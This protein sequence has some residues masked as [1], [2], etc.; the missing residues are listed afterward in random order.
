MT[1]LERAFRE[2]VHEVH[3]A[4]KHMSDPQ[5]RMLLWKW[6]HTLYV[7][8]TPLNVYFTSIRIGK[9][10]RFAEDALE[11]CLWQITN[12]NSSGVQCSATIAMHFTK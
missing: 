6:L 12:E 2:Q 8:V 9:D 5:A 3:D 1:S 10:V 11:H 7:A 4:L